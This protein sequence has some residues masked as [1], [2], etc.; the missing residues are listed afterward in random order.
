MVTRYEVIGTCGG[1]CHDYQEHP[2]GEFVYYDEHDAEIQK[3]NKQIADLKNQI[4][5]S[6]SRWDNVSE[7]FYKE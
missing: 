6:E 2:E 4:I 1:N 7:V 5:K 3:L